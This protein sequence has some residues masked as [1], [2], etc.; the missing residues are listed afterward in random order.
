M[1][2]LQQVVKKKSDKRPHRQ[3]TL[4]SSCHPSPKKM[5]L[6]FLGLH[7]IPAKLL[8]LNLV[9]PEAELT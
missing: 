2:H 6:P 9:T 7:N 1:S 5:S 8:V 4:H 3:G